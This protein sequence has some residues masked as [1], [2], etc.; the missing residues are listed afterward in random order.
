MHVFITGVTGFVGSHLAGF[1]LDR[2][3]RVTGT[4]SRPTQKKID[5]ESFTYISADTQEPGPWQ[6]ELARADGV[7]N[8]AG[9]SI[10]RP[11]TDAHKQAM[12]DSR[13][14]TTRN[15]VAAFPRE[16]GAVLCS[17]SAVGYYGDRGEERLTEG[18]GP[19]D[20]FLA[21]L[22]KD[23]EAEARAAEEKG[24]R[25]AV[26]RFG[27]ILHRE[28]G[29]MEK[30]IPAFRGFLGGPL[31]SGNQWFPW[32][33]LED[34]MAAILFALEHAE[35]SGP[36]NYT[37][38]TPVRNRIF[39]KTLARALNRPAVLTVPSFVLKTVLGE[40]GAVLLASQRVIPQRLSEAGFHW[41]YPEVVEAVE[42]I[43]GR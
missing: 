8:L 42:E 31:G 14:R 2:G 32:V 29:A 40:F 21:E 18:S 13:I 17:T 23:W 43:V 19:G 36:L 9:R 33:H 3:H 7:V 1:L 5:H 41:R 27:I 20:D 35:A 26:M 15:V 25:V 28:G 24:V 39:V 38:P 16:T 6:E 10:F 4:G 12:Y 22:S 37:A 30:M 34:L 11:W